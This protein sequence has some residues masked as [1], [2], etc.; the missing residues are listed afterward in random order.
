MQWDPGDYLRFADHRSR[1]GLELLARVPDLPAR[2]I[3]DLGCG[4]GTLTVSLV[5]R[6]P[7]ARVW[8]VD[9]SEE[10][11]ELARSL[12]APVDWVEADLAGWEPPQPWGDQGLDLVYSNAAL[13]WLGDHDRLLRRLLGLLRPGGVL[14]VQMP[15]NWREPTH[16][17]PARLLDSGVWPAAAEAAL[18]RDRVMTA[19]EYRR[20][21]E[22]TTRSIDMWET[23]YHQVLEPA[24]PST[25]GTAHPVLEWVRG[26]VLRPVLDALDPAARRTFEETCTEGYTAAYPAEPDG[27]VILPFRRLFMVAVR[28]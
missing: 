28:A 17:V 11:L 19:P 7:G 27:R 10:M 3:A 18:A 9:S 20:V 16:T 4:P 22:P 26:S 25:S 6:W 14:A 5:K 2:A 15:D 21:L 23:T 8:G 24:G 12:S 1:P 13:H